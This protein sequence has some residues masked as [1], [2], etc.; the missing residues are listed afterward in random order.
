VTD[1][2]RAAVDRFFVE[3]AAMGV[4]EARGPVRWSD[5]IA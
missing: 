3:A 4:L 2:H 1:G 5:T